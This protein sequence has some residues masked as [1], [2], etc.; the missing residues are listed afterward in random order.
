MSGPTANAYW[1]TSVGQTATRR[2]TAPSTTTSSRS[3]VAR[4]DPVRISVDAV[5]AVSVVVTSPGDRIT[6]A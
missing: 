4:A 1:W 5:V 6:A 2:N 3:I